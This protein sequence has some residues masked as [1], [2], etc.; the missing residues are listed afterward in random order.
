MHATVV[1]AAGRQVTFTGT[2]T[3]PLAKPIQSVVIRASASCSTIGTG[4]IVAT[5]K[6]SPRGAF[7]AHFDLGA[8]QRVV[9]LRAETK[10]R[11]RRRTFSTFTL[12]RG[13]KLVG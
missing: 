10:V 5:V 2:I 8:S 12:I 9:Y 4:A 6:P 7:T 11:N 1:T 3:P 13:V